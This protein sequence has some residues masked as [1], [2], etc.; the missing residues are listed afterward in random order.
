MVE[1]RGFEPASTSLFRATEKR[2]SMSRS[3]CWSRAGNLRMAGAGRHLYYLRRRQS[4]R[5]DVH[6]ALIRFSD[7]ERMQARQA[8]AY[9]AR[10]VLIIATSAMSIEPANE[11]PRNQPGL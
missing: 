4:D 10:L 6:E 5:A 9:V 2:K 3:A 7:A 1:G 8:E 11:Q